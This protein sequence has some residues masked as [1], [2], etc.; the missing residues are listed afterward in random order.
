MNNLLADLIEESKKVSKLEARASKEVH[1][2]NIIINQGRFEKAQMIKRFIDEI[3]N[4]LVEADAIRDKYR[5]Y[6]IVELSITNLEPDGYNRT[7]G[8]EFRDQIVYYGGFFRGSNS[9][10]HNLIRDFS[11]GGYE[12]NSEALA[13]IDGWNAQV[14]NEIETAAA[15]HIK[16]RI[17]ERLQDTKKKL[18]KCSETYRKYAD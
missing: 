3:H 13:L 15:K 8:L 2:Q 6:F 9:I 17:E 1:D 10:S 11:W 5:G 12:F 14:E 4:A 7:L 16:Q 18:I